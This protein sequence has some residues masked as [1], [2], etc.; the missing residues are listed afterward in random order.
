MKG[1]YAKM[2]LSLFLDGFLH[3]LKKINGSKVI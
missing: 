2:C 3:F 1:K